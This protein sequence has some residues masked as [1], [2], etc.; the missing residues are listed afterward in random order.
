MAMSRRCSADGNRAE[1]LQDA[2][3]GP[4]GRSEAAWAPWSSVD[5]G[6]ASSNLQVGQLVRALELDV[7][8]RLARSHRRTG[9]A[10][11]S[12]VPL[13]TPAEIAAFAACLVDASDA[14]I[15]RTVDAMRSRGT[16]VESLYLNLFASAARHLGELWEQD[17]CDFSTVTVGLGR[18]QRLLRELSPAFGAEIDHPLNGRRA[19][20]VQPPDE[21]HSFGLSIVAE[22]FRRAGW[23]IHGGPGGGARN[24]EARVHAEWFDMVGFSIGSEGRLP[25]LRQTIA[26]VRTASLNSALVI[27]VGGPLFTLHPEHVAAVGADATAPDA[28]DAPFLAE[29]LIDAGVGRRS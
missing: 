23:E 20:L 2:A 12:P 11:P 28:K 4:A 26:A 25:W 27:M 18:L 8:P 22:F 16:S 3:N 7:I 6:R 5:G 10:P 29:N 19:M 14:G 9:K 17:L 15:A 13:P 24:P 21:Q 1:L